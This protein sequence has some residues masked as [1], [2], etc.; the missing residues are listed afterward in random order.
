M[1]PTHFAKRV[2]PRIERAV[3]ALRSMSSDT[4]GERQELHS[5]QRRFTVVM[6]DLEETLFL[7]EMI[8]QL[9]ASAP[10]V[11]LKVKPF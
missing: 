5:L 8:E 6:S 9:A 4:P 2:L 3:G 11:G 1:L 7:P 10:G